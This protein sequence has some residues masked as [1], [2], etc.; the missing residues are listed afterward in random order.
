MKTILYRYHQSLIHFVVLLILIAA[1][2][3]C[4][5]Q[6]TT[7]PVRRKMVEAVFANGYLEYENQYTVAANAAGIVK[8]IT[9]KE[10]DSVQAK[11]LLAYIQ[12]VGQ[13]EAL[14]QSYSVYQNALQNSSASSP[15]LIKAQQQV[16]QAKLD[17]AQAKT[18]YERYAALMKT[19]SVAKIDFDEMQMRYKNAQH[20]LVA[21][22]KDYENLRKDLVLQFTTSKEAWQAQQSVVKNYKIWSDK[23][24][25]VIELF[26]K[27]GEVLKVGEPLAEIG[28][29]TIHIK[30]FVAEEDIVKVDKGQTIYIHLNTYTDRTF[31]ARVTKIYPGFNTDQQSYTVEAAF[32]EM[33]EKLFSGTQLQAN[34]E[35]SDAK[36]AL[37]IP[38][39]YL[40]PNN[41]VRLEDGTT[42]T[43]KVGTKDSQ[44]V[45]VLGGISE[46]DVII[47]NNNQ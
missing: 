39:A 31:K 8:G 12:N 23:P 47:K 17:L 26:H 14:S 6:E 41:T 40:L 3:S 29:G 45:Q 15:Q 11:Q 28:N 42:K 46:Q 37:M 38:T 20:R 21:E 33:P 9:I 1:L 10:G 25:L 32:L 36:E 22:Q 34:V 24:G 35:L 27:N 30:L 16:D 13:D 4:S 7:S 43:I 44:W 5:H 18:N 19:N 2:G